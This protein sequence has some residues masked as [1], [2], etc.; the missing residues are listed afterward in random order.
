MES[1]QLEAVLGLV[2]KDRRLL[3]HALVHRSYAN[4]QGWPPTSSYER[5]EYLGDAVLELVVSDELYR[6]LPDLSEGE[7]TKG[8]S[9]LVRGE[10]LA[11]VA[12]RCR[13]GGVPEVGQGGGGHR[14]PA[15]GVD[16]G[17]LSSKLWWRRCTWTGAT[18]GPSN[19]SSRPWR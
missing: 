15:E 9:T 11:Q 18:P 3:D 5:L 8:R 16:P 1:G 10:T 6:R 14:R 2:F 7:L 4:E 17:R 13:L 12:E 19:L